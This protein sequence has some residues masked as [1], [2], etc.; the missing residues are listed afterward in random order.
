MK[1]LIFVRTP[2]QL[3]VALYIKEQFCKKGDI[4]D[5]IVTETFNNN[6][7]IVDRLNSLKI[8]N[9]IK[10]LNKKDYQFLFEKKNKIKKLYYLLTFKPMI[11]NIFGSMDIYDEFYFWNYDSMIIN[12]ISYLFYKNNNLKAFIFEE[13]YI[14]YFPLNEIF[15]ERKI[16]KFMNLR[17]KLLGIK[18]I[19]FNSI[20]GYLFFNPELSIFDA[21][22]KKYKI[23]K[24]LVN[25]KKVKKDIKYLFDIKK[26]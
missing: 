17:N 12:L 1:K 22:I 18:K 25:D 16:H 14:S 20:D 9:S 11:K 3:I 8:F 26:L 7:I 23:N 21:K 13:G 4:V 6:K 2:Y 24:E 19:N 15:P 10:I 5:L